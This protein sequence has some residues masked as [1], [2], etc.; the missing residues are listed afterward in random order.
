RPPR[1]RRRRPR[2]R[3]RGERR[4]GPDH[5]RGRRR[6][7]RARLHPAR[8]RPPALARLSRVP[9]DHVTIRVSDLETSLR[10][11]D[12]AFALLGF[13]GERHDSELGHEWE[14]F[15]IAPAD[16]EQLPTHGLHAGFAARSR[17]QV[18]EWWA[19]MRDEGAP[20]DGAPGPR[21]EYG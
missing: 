18:D 9:I 11:Y 2:P 10:F 4:R 3:P 15:S 20:D 8:G 17:E 7:A 1:R 13:A 14:D 6:G 5:L 19:A 21:P 16:A 12:R